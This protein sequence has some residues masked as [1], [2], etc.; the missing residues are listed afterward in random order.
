MEDASLKYNK[1]ETD[2]RETLFLLLLLLIISK[3]GTYS[4]EMSIKKGLSRSERIP[5][6]SLLPVA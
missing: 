4:V 6:T 5:W 2:K 1:T 3:K